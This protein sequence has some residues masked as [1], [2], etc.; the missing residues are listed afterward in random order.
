VAPSGGDLAQCLATCPLGTEQ[1]CETVADCSTGQTCAMGDA[2][3]D[4][5]Q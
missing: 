1:V 3:F 5:C 2:V 4:T